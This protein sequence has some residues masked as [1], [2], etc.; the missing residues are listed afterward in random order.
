[1]MTPERIKAISDAKEL[2]MQERQK[3]ERAFI[4]DRLRVSQWCEGL[5]KAYD[6]TSADVRAK[7]PPLPGTTPETMLPSL[8]ADEPDEGA[9]RKEAEVLLQIQEAMNREAE[10]LYMQVSDASHA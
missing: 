6:R 8:F 2:H 9:Y 7:M 3:A 10:R 4:E 5:V 1:M